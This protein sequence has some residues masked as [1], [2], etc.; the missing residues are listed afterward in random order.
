M[1]GL[2]FV[3]PHSMAVERFMK[4]CGLGR[5]EGTNE[6]LDH[7]A[8]E[9][10][11]LQML[12]AWAAGIAEPEEGSVA[13]DAL[14]GGSPQAAYSQ[15]MGEHVRTWAARFAQKL[16]SETRLAYFRSAAMLLKALLPVLG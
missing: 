9:F 14:P 1:Q 12:A 5:P 8:T 15:F 3:N 7:I 13:L 6:P 4:S 11:L 10:E 16:L 2:L